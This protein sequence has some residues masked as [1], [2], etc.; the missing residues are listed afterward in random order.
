MEHKLLSDIGITSQTDSESTSVNPISE[1]TR[2]T[3]RCKEYNITYNKIPTTLAD[4]ISKIQNSIFRNAAGD[5]KQTIKPEK[6]QHSENMN[7]IDL[8]S[9]YVQQLLNSFPAEEESNKSDDVSE[10]NNDSVTSVSKTNYFTHLPIHLKTEDSHLIPVS[11]SAD[12]LEHNQNNDDKRRKEREHD[13]IKQIDKNLKSITDTYKIY[14]QQQ[15]ASNKESYSMKDYKQQNYNIIPGNN[16]E[17]N[18][19]LLNTSNILLKQRL[20]ENSN[21]LNKLNTT[22]DGKSK[23][24]NDGKSTNFHSYLQGAKENDFVPSSVGTQHQSKNNTRASYNNTGVQSMK[25]GYNVSEPAAHKTHKGERFHKL[26]IYNGLKIPVNDKFNVSHT[27]KM[28]QTYNETYDSHLRF[29]RMERHDDKTSHEE[30]E[31]TITEHTSLEHSMSAELKLPVSMPGKVQNIKEELR[32]S[33]S[34]KGRDPRFGN[35]ILIPLNIQNSTSQRYESN[36]NRNMSQSEWFH[37]SKELDSMSLPVNL[38]TSDHE[39]EHYQAV[40]SKQTKIVDGILYLKVP[41]NLQTAPYKVKVPVI[42][43][44][45]GKNNIIQNNKPNTEKCRCDCSNCVK[46]EEYIQTNCNIC[47]NTSKIGDYVQTNCTICNNASNYEYYA[48]NNCRICNNASNNEGYVQTNCTV[49]NNRTKNNLLIDKMTKLKSSNHTSNNSDYFSSMLENMSSFKF[50]N[51]VFSNSQESDENLINTTEMINDITSVSSVDNENTKITHWDNILTS[52]KTNIFTSNYLKEGN[53]KNEIED[54]FTRSDVMSETTDVMQYNTISSTTPH[55]DTMKYTSLPQR[56]NITRS[57]KNSPK[58]SLD[59]EITRKNSTYSKQPKIIFQSIED[60]KNNIEELNKN[61]FENG[62]LPANIWEEFFPSTTQDYATYSSRS[63]ASFHMEN[64]KTSFS[65]VN[66]HPEFISTSLPMHITIKGNPNYSNEVSGRTDYEKEEI[67]SKNIQNHINVTNNY[68]T[69]LLV[70]SP[71]S[72]LPCRICVEANSKMTTSLNKEANFEENENGRERNAYSHQTSTQLKN[73]ENYHKSDYEDDSWMQIKLHKNNYDNGSS[74][75]I[76]V[77]YDNNTGSDYVS[78]IN[79]K[80]TRTITTQSQSE[81]HING[82]MQ[83]NI[84]NNEILSKCPESKT[85]ADCKTHLLSNYDFKIPYSETE[86]NSPYQNTEHRLMDDKNSVENEKDNK[87]DNM[88][89]YENQSTDDYKIKYEELIKLQ[90]LGNIQNIPIE[91]YN[92]PGVVKVFSDNLQHPDEHGISYDTEIITQQESPI[93]DASIFLPRNT[94]PHSIN[95]YQSVVPNEQH[96]IDIQISTEQTSN[97]TQ[98]IDTESSKDML[99]ENKY[100]SE[101]SDFKMHNLNINQEE[102]IP[103]NSEKQMRKTTIGSNQLLLPTELY[104]STDQEIHENSTKQNILTI[105]K[106]PATESNILKYKNAQTSSKFDNTT[107]Q[108]VTNR[109]L[110]SHSEQNNSEQSAESPKLGQTGTCIK[111]DRDGKCTDSNLDDIMMFV[112][113]NKEKIKSLL[114]YLSSNFFAIN[115]SQNNKSRNEYESSENKKHE[116]NDTEYIITNSKNNLI[117]S[118]LSYENKTEDFPKDNNI[119]HRENLTFPK[120]RSEPHISRKQR[121]SNQA[122][123]INKTTKE[124]KKSMTFQKAPSSNMANSLQRLLST[125]R[126]KINRTEYSTHKSQHN[127]SSS[128]DIFNQN[129]LLGNLQHDSTFSLDQNKIQDGGKVEAYNVNGKTYAHMTDSDRSKK[130]N[131]LPNAGYYSNFLNKENIITDN[132]SNNHLVGNVLISTCDIKSEG[133]DKVSLVN[134]SNTSVTKQTN[135]SLFPRDNQ[136]QF[137]KLQDTQKTN[138]FTKDVL[139]NFRNDKDGL[140]VSIFLPL[141]VSTD[142]KISMMSDNA[143]KYQNSTI[144]KDKL[145]MVNKTENVTLNRG[146]ST[147]G[148]KNNLIKAARSEEETDSYASGKEEYPTVQMRSCQSGRCRG[149]LMSEINIMKSILSWMK[150]M[151]T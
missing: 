103:K 95:T 19:Q 135:T 27:D 74:N 143:D 90:N 92:S 12:Q 99:N 133:N 36:N 110:G 55:S 39:S 84:I 149:I 35:F 23:H 123:L 73:D 63:A 40:P 130:Y 131:V 116:S 45:F 3:K 4:L 104:S 24:K 112:V 142:V 80:L 129:A 79:S 54:D 17:I 52:L 16:N 30:T 89:Q 125:S 122:S 87:Q 7:K 136:N 1:E 20:R 46:S 88:K 26:N 67:N 101:P 15:I 127:L 83:N 106:F 76:T 28:N 105:H 120:I 6:V 64:V 93:R 77:Q 57:N 33:E 31:N 111:R 139:K 144:Q 126:I 58:L 100:Y 11:S 9:E 34:Y 114:D 146:Q 18:K 42:L 22:E 72:L 71:Q 14:L 97:N 78:E 61:E 69:D 115:T 96:Q 151:V 86:E 41:A 2:K 32:L 85:S 21:F 94:S 102:V 121:H 138:N 62:T 5:K 140:Q 68:G 119:T 141:H 53:F 147:F 60:S 25:V 51:E 150:D 98:G 132:T 47:N 108:R 137:V 13:D 70:P 81:F 117:I 66:E 10:T 56:R 109:Y 8:K 37:S 44:H 82:Q 48:Q 91:G 50:M 59:L 43:S 107:N 124:D 75:S 134:K 145:E 113:D 148:S 128:K 118:A 38:F 29:S 49:C 65:N